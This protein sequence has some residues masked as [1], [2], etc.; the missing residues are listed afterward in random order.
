MACKLMADLG[1]R[2]IKVEP[3]EGDWTRRYGPFPGH[4]ADPEK[5]GLFIYL[6]A[7]KLGVSLDSS[8]PAG[9][10]K[11]DSILTGADI[12][13]HNVAVADRARAGLDDARLR[14][15]F[16]NLI[17]TAISPFG[18]FGPH[19]DWKAHE[20][21][22]VNA[23]GWAHLNPG[24]SHFP[25]LPPL[26]S[27]GHPGLFHTGIH[28]CVVALAAL[29]DRT[30]GVVARHS[31]ISA[32]ECVAAMLE[33][34]FVHYS[35][36]GREASRLGM[37]QAAPWTILECADGHIMV[38][39][40]EEAQWKGLVE[41][42]G[43]PDWAHEDIFADLR[44]RAL[45]ADAL[46]ALMGD[47]IKDWKKADLFREAQVK[48]IPMAP[49]SSM[50]DLYASEQLRARE[51]FVPLDQPGVGRLS[52]PGAPFKST[53]GGWRIG[54]AAPRLGEHNEIIEPRRS[55]EPRAAS[56]AKVDHEPRSKNRLP[57][58]GIRVLDLTW[59]W[60]GPHCTLQ[61]AHLGAEIIRIES[62]HR[63][64]A[65]RR[66]PP[67]A[68]DIPGVNRAGYFNQYSQG[69]RSLTLN[70][71]DPRGVEIA[72]ELV[73]HCD[74]VADN[75]SA[76]AMDRMGLGYEVLHKIRPDII[77]VSISGCGQTGP[78]RKLLSYGPPSA[79]L[80]GFCSVTGYAGLGPAE[81]GVSFPDPTAGVL[82][83]VAVMAALH[84]RDRTGEGQHIDLSQLEA[85]VTLLPAALL[86]YSLNGAPPARDGNRDPIMAPHNTYKAFGDENQ[87][88]SIAV[89]DDDEWRAMCTV[90]A[91]PQLADDARFR[92]LADRKANEDA[93]D[94][95]VTAW[96]RGRDRWEITEALQRAGVAAF[97]SMSNK[98]LAHDTHMLER[99]FF[100]N[101]DHP[102]VGRR[103]HAGIPWR[104]S[105]AENRVRG[106]APLLGADTDAILKTMLGMSDEKIAE[107][108]A[109]DVLA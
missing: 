34:S 109:L 52:V 91:M 85:T 15:R 67:F 37:R 31:E 103:L 2:V 83:S 36:A 1:A 8:S 62:T 55:A 80:A 107:L 94:E 50:A 106:P 58:D 17:A 92:K 105:D 16:P 63:L 21:N 7:G 5:S 29:W 102:E 68:D 46:Y 23:G 9:L 57:L 28:A 24:S 71:S 12:L 64:D 51:F 60:A 96:T 65:T 56:T 45:N 70:L 82:G 11:L 97:P 30:R 25:E 6:N 73:R 75:F 39:C 78:W 35:Y 108:R 61:F 81:T 86:E 54:G 47:W 84:H 48:R 89:A 19:R 79:A 40:L 69:K 59:V 20:L 76:G 72:R 26:K 10:A 41:L 14:K 32:Q 49:V 87:W 98:D 88:V 3:P 90:M 74:I 38:L 43:N 22:I 53:A 93:L 100:T 42:M 99:G 27:F 104:L 101:F 95:I 4:R 77:V 13:V 33:L 18:D 66:V 44:T